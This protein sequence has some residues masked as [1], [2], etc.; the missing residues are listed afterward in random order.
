MGYPPLLLSD[1][2]STSYL[3]PLL[4]LGLL[5]TSVHLSFVL[6][7]TSPAR[8]SITQGHIHIP[9][10]AGHTVL[11]TSQDVVGLLDHMDTLLAHVQPPA[12]QHPKV[13]FHPASFQPLLLK[14]VV[15]HRVV[16][17]EVE[18]PALG[19]VETHKIGLDPSVQSVQIPLQSLPPLKQVNTHSQLGAICKLT[20]GALNHRITESQNIRGWKGP[21][22]VI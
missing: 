22:W 19:L 5:T 7:L 6:H 8:P 16:V 3:L 14:P 2:I 17:T 11:D 15:L 12:K 13:L 1:K 21:P 10:P 18:D 20:E 9:A 4:A